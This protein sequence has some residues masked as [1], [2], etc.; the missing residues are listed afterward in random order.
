MRACLRDYITSCWR[1][2]ILQ[3]AVARDGLCFPHKKP[4]HRTP[5]NGVGTVPSPKRGPL[6]STGERV[7]LQ[8]CGSGAR[9]PTCTRARVHSSCPRGASGGHMRA[10]AT[11][12][13]AT[14]RHL[15]TGW[16]PGTPAEDG[17]GLIRCTASAKR[18]ATGGQ[19]SRHCGH[20]KGGGRTP[21]GSMQPPLQPAPAPPAA[22]PSPCPAAYLPAGGAT[23]QLTS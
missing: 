17:G 12:C 2:S 22:S 16:L 14:K 20:E 13:S 8:S 7:H 10:L 19:M 11:L 21:R 23:R 4:A 5:Q 1:A 18:W 9:T 6:P 15:L 3:A